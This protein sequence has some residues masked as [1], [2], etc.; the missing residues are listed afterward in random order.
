MENARLY[1]L[2]DTL[3]AIFIAAGPESTEKAG[4]IGD[5][6]I[7]T[8]SK[9]EIVQKFDGAGKMGRP[10]IGQVTVGWGKSEPEARKTAYEWW[11]TAARSQIGDL[12]T[13]RNDDW[14][15]KT[16]TRGRHFG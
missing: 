15:V 6:L 12:L 3:P 11:R 16:I 1:S 4:R 5:G 14:I 13:F 7:S 10:H 2:P 8:A 9:K